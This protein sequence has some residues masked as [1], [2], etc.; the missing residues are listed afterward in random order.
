MKK[1]DLSAQQIMDILKE[2]AYVLSDR[3]D[4]E[5]SLSFGEKTNSDNLFNNF[6]K[7]MFVEIKSLNS[8]FQSKTTLSLDISVPFHVTHEGS[9]QPGTIDSCILNIWGNRESFIRRLFKVTGID[10]THPCVHPVEEEVDVIYFQFGMMTE[11]YN[12]VF[13]HLN[14]TYLTSALLKLAFLYF[15]E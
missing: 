9:V 15:Q 1:N 11:E 5:V 14:N 7:T 8:L 6:D 2:Y 4:F 3:R 12:E 13:T 10:E